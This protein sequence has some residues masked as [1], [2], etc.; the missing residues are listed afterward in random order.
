MPEVTLDKFLLSPETIWVEPEKG[1][2]PL[3]LFWREK[4]NSIIFSFVCWNQWL[5]RNISSKLKTSRSGLWMSWSNLSVVL[6]QHPKF[7]R[8]LDRS[9]NDVCWPSIMLIFYFENSKLLNFM[10]REY[11]DFFHAILQTS[12]L[13]WFFF[14]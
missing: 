6:F 7:G 4:D 3:N 9:I 5:N 13:R 12:N 2:K 11:S 10:W 8:N 14:G 1:T